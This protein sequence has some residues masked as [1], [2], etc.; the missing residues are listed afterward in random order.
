MSQLIKYSVCIKNAEDI[1]GFR[2]DMETTGGG[3]YIPNR[4]IPFISRYGLS[5]CITY[6]LTKEEA[7][8]VEK[9]PRVRFVEIKLDGMIAQPH[10]IK[11]NQIFQYGNSTQNLS[12][13][14]YRVAS[15][16]PTSNFYLNNTSKYGTISTGFTGRGK[17]IDI[18]MHDT[19]FDWNHP[20]FTDGSGNSR[21]VKYNWY[22]HAGQIANRGWSVNSDGTQTS[23]SGVQ[24]PYTRNWWENE[25]HGTGGASVSAGKIH[26]F[27][28]EATLYNIRGLNSGGPG[29]SRVI[30]YIWF[31]HNN[32]PNHAVYGNK[33]PT[34]V[35]SSLG[36]FY[37]VGTGINVYPENV[38]SSTILPN[39]SGANPTGSGRS[40]LTSINFNG[41]TYY[42]PFTLGQLR[43]QF[44]WN[45]FN[46]LGY[47]YSYNE[48]LIYIQ[49][50][51]QSVEQ[52]FIDTLGNTPGLLWFG[53]A[54]NNQQYYADSS[55]SAYYNLQANYSDGG[56]HRP[57]RGSIMNEN[58]G[59]VM[60]GALWP[61]DYPA[62]YT[63]RGSRIDIVS[64]TNVIAAY[65]N[66][67]YQIYTGTSCASPITAG[68]AALW[69]EQQ[70]KNG[71]YSSIT[72][73]NLRNIFR[74]TDTLSVSNQLLSSG[75]NW[76]DDYNTTYTTNK[77]LA[78]ASNGYAKQIVPSNISASSIQEVYGGSYPI[79]L[80]EYSATS[81]GQLRHSSPSGIA[82]TQFDILSIDATP[83][84]L[85]GS[86]E[87]TVTC[88][89]PAPYLIP[90]F[91]LADGTSFE[92]VFIRPGESKVIVRGILSNSG[93][94][95]RT[96]VLR[97]SAIDDNYA[98]TSRTCN[99]SIFPKAPGSILVEGLP[100]Y[101]IKATQT[102]V[103][104]GTT[105]TFQVNTININNGTIFYWTIENITT[106]NSNFSSSGSGS[107]TINNNSATF[108]VTTANDNIPTG[109]YYYFHALLRLGSISGGEI[110]RSNI[111]GIGDRV[112]TTLV[113]DYSTTFTVPSG[114]TRVTFKLWGAGGS[115]AGA[116]G[117]NGGYT[118][119]TIAVSSGQ[120]FYINP[121]Q[122]SWV[123]NDDVNYGGGKRSKYDNGNSGGDGGGRSWVQRSDI[124]HD[125]LTAGGGGGGSGGFW[126][127]R[128]AGTTYSIA[129]GSGGGLQGGECIDERGGGGGGQSGASNKIWSYN[130]NGSGIGIWNDN[131]AILPTTPA[132]P[133][134]FAYGSKYMG[135]ETS[136][137]W[138]GG[139]GGG[140]W[141][142][143]NAG[144]GTDGGTTY[145]RAG[146]AGGGGGSGW[147]GRNG[148]S[149]L[150][151]INYG[152][153]TSPQDINGRTDSVSGITYYNTVCI[154]S[155]QAP[156]PVAN[157]TDPDYGNNAGVGTSRTTPGYGR[158]VVIYYS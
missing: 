74:N 59:I 98:L 109:K 58:Y 130:G 110:A 1:E 103:S 116:P 111:V 61:Y 91:I 10:L 39:L 79:G 85:G 138:T 37:T 55:D 128:E 30:W 156:F 43:S 127:G 44:R 31:F 65:D 32:K 152:S 147:V 57:L 52:D 63:A 89:A 33:N 7:E 28:P 82:D 21:V 46:Q 6:Y 83:T 126:S 90:I 120:V 16:N 84:N 101:S 77:I 105:V 87:I 86:Y 48:L 142:G 93:Q 27:A 23:Y 118:E 17:D 96:I 108:T 131:L 64:P 97:T 134:A 149:F 129:G 2:Q 34:I 26:G 50:W 113:Y 124:A 56:Y 9:D 5:R 41:A 72:G 24:Y 117:G 22:A 75:S 38:T 158:I 73:A 8:Q 119:S 54:G 121:G 146:H 137:N 60:V 76:W 62:S 11:S 35:N 133:A 45:L 123:R 136:E 51:S 114:V 19:H 78:T 15:R 47:D 144:F 13:A 115:G 107:I 70:R 80:G 20:E 14:T 71:N 102:S 95:T 25:T 135:G 92:S 122:A 100:A 106:T 143:G 12:W 104:E 68:V 53:S 112:K 139:G 29:S 145:L 148:S 125:I 49:A 151:G 141:I 18:V 150:S 99:W 140:G 66:N 81:Y 40:Y 155:P 157:S 88:T 69:A 42:P 3:L 4:E 94:A 36:F 154:Q 153:L 132:V 67:Q